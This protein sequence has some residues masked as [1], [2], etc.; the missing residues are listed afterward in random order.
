MRLRE[1]CGMTAEAFSRLTGIGYAQLVAVEQGRRELSDIDALIISAAT[2]VDPSF[3]R[4]KTNPAIKGLSGQKYELGTFDFWR[5]NNLPQIRELLEEGTTK[6]QTESLEF[7]VA[8]NAKELI[9]AARVRGQEL[10]VFH[11]LQNALAQTAER[12]GI[13]DALAK[14]VDVNF[15]F[16]PLTKSGGTSVEIDIKTHK[17]PGLGRR[18]DDRPEAKIPSMFDRESIR[19]GVDLLRQ[20]FKPSWSK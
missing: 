14:W 10:A 18:P 2:G 8:A 20:W 6:G 16:K 11:F 7:A 5:S 19:V 9:S 15:T 12:F 3:N 13:G 17:L 4:E 1:L